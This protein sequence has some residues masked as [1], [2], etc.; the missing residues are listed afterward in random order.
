MRSAVITGLSIVFILI[1]FQMALAESILFSGKQVNSEDREFIRGR[2]VIFRKD[3]DTAKVKSLKRGGGDMRWI[4]EK[5]LDLAII[6]WIDKNYFTKDYLKT[7]CSE[8]IKIDQWGNNYDLDISHLLFSLAIVYDWFS[9]DFDTAFR[10]KLGDFIYRHAKFM[11]E[12]AVKTQG[13][14]WTDSLWQNHAWINH[15][16]LLASGMALSGQYEEAKDWVAFSRARL[17]KIIDVQEKNGSNHEGL[18]YSIYGNI[19]LVRG[20][21]LLQQYDENIFQK[22]E[23]L[24]NYYKYY[25]AYDVDG[26]LTSFFDTGDSPR[27][28]WYNPCEIFLKLYKEYGMDEYRRLYEFYRDRYD[29]ITVGLFSSVYGIEKPRKSGKLIPAIPYFNADL[30]LF[31]DKWPRSG[32]INTSFL[33]KSGVPGGKNAN[34]LLKTLKPSHMNRSHEH[35][36]QNHFIV[37]NNGEYLVSDTEYT[38]KKLSK[39]HNTLLVGGLG[40]LGEGERWFRDGDINNRSFSDRAGLQE[41]NIFTSDE[42]NIVSA[43]AAEFYADSVGLKSFRRTIVWLKKYGF[44]I[45]DEVTCKEKKSLTLCFHSDL[46]MSVNNKNEVVFKSAKHLRSRLINLYPPRISIK[47]DR[48]NVVTHPN[49]E[50]KD[51]GYVA[52]MDITPGAEKQDFINVLSLDGVIPAIVDVQPTYYKVVWAE[53]IVYLSKGDMGSEIVCDGERVTGKVVIGKAENTV[54]QVP[55][56]YTLQ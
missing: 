18:N 26:R 50:M 25:L 38:D 36:D 42:V 27:Y 53:D 12:Y 32:D 29:T 17:E 22:S 7:W 28:L 10:K 52:A 55:L 34:A 47:A 48:Y 37:W 9:N 15:T 8:A 54:H 11:H 30:G 13:G 43:D 20:M 3:F 46:P 4:G 5:I 45:F 23:Y 49:G 51:R 1:G 24:K 2:T 19:W 35:P 44:I 41:R 40:Q 39:D 33:F 6:Y 16:A 14:W 31:I 21:T 56:I